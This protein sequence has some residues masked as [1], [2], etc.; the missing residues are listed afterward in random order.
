MANINKL[1]SKIN[2]ASQAVKSAK[3]IKSKIGS[4]GYKG[5]VNTEEV[6][7]LQEQAEENRRKLEERR[8]GLQKQLSSATKAGSKAKRS[9]SGEAIFL[10]YP[11]DGDFDNY[12][13]FTTRERKKR[14]GG[15]LLAEETVSIALPLPEDGWSQDSA[16]KFGESEMGAVARGIDAKVQGG[17]EAGGV[18][19]EAMNAGKAFI[20]DAFGSI[21]GGIGNLRAGR[22]KN[23]M[24][25]QTLEEIEFRSFEFSWDMYPRSQAEAIEIQKIIYAF[26]VASLPDTFAAKDSETAVENF[27]N[28]PNV[29]EIEIDGPLADNVERFLPCVCTKVDVKVIDNADNLIAQSSDSF[30]SGI[31]SISVG[32]TEI[33]LMSQEVYSSRVAP[34]NMAEFGSTLGTVTDASGSPSL[35]D[36]ISSTNNS[37]DG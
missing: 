19:E 4:L 27:M 37:G 23:P 29:F 8:A 34:K 17:A 20:Q 25:E 3:G 21:G 14:E 35:L 1:L 30:F 2:Q 11:V 28:Y 12:L 7:K 22:A 10:E 31:T 24:K 6:D 15:N 9:P 16:T 32:F 18:I 13:V 33:K 26:R 5:G 36:E